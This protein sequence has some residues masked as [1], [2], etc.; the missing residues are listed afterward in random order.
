MFFSEKNEIIFL[1]FAYIFKDTM[2]INPAKI[3]VEIKVKN[4]IK[5][6][7]SNI[8]ID[9]YGDLKYIKEKELKKIAVE[10]AEGQKE[11]ILEINDFLNKEKIWEIDNYDRADFF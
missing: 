11:I 2:N 6:E 4:N 10:I 1:F 5:I 3:E 7:V 8:Y 9:E